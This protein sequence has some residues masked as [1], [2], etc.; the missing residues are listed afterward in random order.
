M[1]NKNQEKQKKLAEELLQMSLMDKKI[2]QSSET[3]PYLPLSHQNG[4][5]EK[6][7]LLKNLPQKLEEEKPKPEN[8]FRQN[9]PTLSADK[10]SFSE[11]HKSQLEAQKQ[12][13]QLDQDQYGFDTNYAKRVKRNGKWKTESPTNLF[14]QFTAGAIRPIEE[15]IAG[16][17]EASSMPAYRLPQEALTTPQKVARKAGHVAGALAEALPMTRGMKAIGLGNTLFKNMAKKSVQKNIKEGFKDDLQD[18][19]KKYSMQKLTGKALDSSLGAAGLEALKSRGDLSQT[20]EAA[21]YG[22]IS[23]FISKKI[24]DPLNDVRKELI[25]SLAKSPQKNKLINHSLDFLTEETVD[26]GVKAPL[27]YS[28]DQIIKLMQQGQKENRNDRPKE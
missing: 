6:N 3:N 8:P 10:R 22:G 17:D 18:R 23:P 28:Q 26:A 19:A 15:S 4:A 1:L 24:T 11:R 12:L 14:E 9:Y 27:K 13:R 20:A 21:V 2:N 7:L 16:E 5:L 25:P